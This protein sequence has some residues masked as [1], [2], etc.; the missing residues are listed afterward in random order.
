MHA[1][2]MVWMMMT[3]LVWMMM[4]VNAEGGAEMDA[5]DYY[6]DGSTRRSPLKMEVVAGMSLSLRLS[7]RLRLVGA[8]T[9]ASWMWCADAE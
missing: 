7:L 3:R 1:A 4:V 9:W 8:L 5:K 6:D 2:R